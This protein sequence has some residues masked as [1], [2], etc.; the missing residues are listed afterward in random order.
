LCQSYRSDNRRAYYYAEPLGS[1][2]GRYEGP[3]Y[4]YE[5]RYDRYEREDD[6]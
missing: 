6:D 5:R 3:N 2:Q 4:R 1:D